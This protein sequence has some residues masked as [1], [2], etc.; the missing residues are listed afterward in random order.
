M[1]PVLLENQSTA[2]AGGN[3]PRIHHRGDK[4]NVVRQINDLSCVSAAGQMLAHEYGVNITQEM[5]IEEIGTPSTAYKLSEFLNRI[6]GEWIGG[7]VDPDNIEVYLEEIRTKPAIIAILR[8]P[9]TMGHAVVVKGQNRLGNFQIFDPFDQTRYSM[10]RESFIQF[11]S[12]V[13]VRI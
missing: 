4:R 8:E 5:L 9:Q 7:H 1:S 6:E 11:F 3:W 12:E 13:I 10:S 2:G